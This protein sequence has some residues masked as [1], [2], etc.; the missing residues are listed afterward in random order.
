MTNGS[1]VESG[2]ISPK[3]LPRYVPGKVLSSSKGLNWKDLSQCTYAYAGQD[4]EL[5][6]MDSFMIVQYRDGITPMD[7]QFDGKWTRTKCAPGHFSLLSRGVDTHWNWFDDLV[8]SHIYLDNALLRRVAQDVHDTNVDQVVLY[9]VLQ[10]S[11]PIIG[12]I[13]DQLTVEAANS[14]S[15]GAMYAEALSVQLAV[16][17]LRHYAEVRQ[18]LNKPPGYLSTKDLACL[19]EF[20]D[21]HMHEKITLEQLADLVGMGAWTLNRYLRAATGQSVYGLVQQ[22]RLSHARALLKAQNPSLKQ[23]AAKCGFSDQAHMTRAFK[24]AMGLTPGQ[25]RA[26]L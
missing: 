23:I 17:L 12:H 1:I 21:A 4:V 14:G 20:I 7:R 2:L 10:G 6:P 16:Y 19:N 8:V 5:P 18:P 11:D 25:F 15:A 3:D 26:S 9:D 24:K 13:V 22:K